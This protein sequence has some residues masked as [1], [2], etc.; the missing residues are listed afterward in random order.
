VGVFVGKSR[1]S[2]REDVEESADFRE[3]PTE[4]SD[5][6]LAE[7]MTAQKRSAV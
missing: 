2:P 1:R 4:V 3:Y 5:P 6:M 7:R